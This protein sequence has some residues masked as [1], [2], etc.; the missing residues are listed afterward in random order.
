MDTNELMGVLESLLG[1][2]VAGLSAPAARAR[3][4]R[5]TSAPATEPQVA[6]ASEPALTP[7]PI[8]PAPPEP[9][10][11]PPTKVAHGSMTAL[12]AAE[13]PVGLA[14]L[15]ASTLTVNRANMP[16]INLIGKPWTETQIVGRT[17]QEIAPGFADSEVEAAFR[18]VA[19][20][21]TP[22]SAIIEES[23]PTGPIFRRCTLSAIRG[24]E[25]RFSEL[26]FTMLDVTEQM[27]ARQRAEIE[28]QRAEERAAR[29]EEQALRNSVRAAAMEALARVS[30]LEDA[31]GRVAERT[32]EALGDCCAVFLLGEDD[33]L[34]LSA[35]YH[36]DRG[37][38]FRMRAAYL[39][40]PLHRGEGLIGQVVLAGAGNLSARW[41]TGDLDPM[42]ATQRD[43]LRG[44]PIASLM[45]APLRESSRSFGAL[46][47]FSAREDSGGSARVYTGADLN[48]LQELADQ[49]AQAV[50]NVRLRDALRAAQGEREALLEASDEGIAIY[51]AQGRLRH[52][53]GI[54][55]QLLS[56]PTGAPSA[57]AADP[58][59]RRRFLSMSG[60]ELDGE[61]LPWAR[62]LQGERVGELAMERMVVEW[63]GGVRR[64]LA[65]RAVPVE[66]GSGG[67]CGAVL[68]LGD[69][70]PPTGDAPAG[71]AV[72]GGEPQPTAEAEWARWRETMELFADGVVLCDN[73]GTVV[74]VNTAGHELLNLP[75][76]PGNAQERQAP[77]G[78]WQRLRRPDGEPLAVGEDPAAM[79]LAGQ[80]VQDLETTVHLPS[81]GVRRVFWDARRIAGAVGD[82]LGVVLIARAATEATPGP[83][84]GP[85]TPLGAAPVSSPAT[86]LAPTTLLPNR[87]TPKLASTGPAPAQPATCDLAEVCARVA[88]AH[89][90]AQG[91]RLE[92]RLPRRQVRVLA[93]DGVVQAATDALITT[94]AATLPAAAPLHVAVWVERSASEPPRGPSTLVPPAV[95]VAQI[96]TLRLAPGQLPDLASIVPSTRAV[97]L[98]AG[99]ARTNVAVVRICSP[100]LGTGT[101]AGTEPPPE[102]VE[103][104]K[105]RSLV[106]QVGGRAWA[107]QD[108][109]LGPT[110]SFS[111]P[112]AE[113]A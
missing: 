106:A 50:Q 1:P 38:G 87:A 28:A 54:G 109:L 25:G 29:V 99:G 52:L 41:A 112:L 21:G 59:S 43:L 98:G 84:T 17:L 7:A 48:F 9:M 51:D 100:G 67:V 82:V 56:R 4:R 88:R 97:A 10:P 16:F 95:D 36:R 34:Q 74:F 31:L 32:A 80:T 89:S 110:Y 8:A 69:S 27:V 72:Q 22:F 39:A 3:A 2:A 12:L 105:C 78:L 81:G 92:I 14:V 45:C 103:F 111:I 60:M 91:R 33:V 30:D 61:Q 24:T 96:N 40:A 18:Q 20:T 102:T 108:P 85:L 90:G 93:E 58:A 71:P 46:L 104:L 94:G 44:A 65:V 76:P 79:A 77:T 19:R 47:L 86:A 42:G 63:G 70:A 101:T 15:S 57:D 37:L 13:T 68:L 64:E 62:A 55:R 5:A 83:T 66:D 53:N 75:T 107:K 35:L 23:T 49:I 11:L 26:L 6:P 73:S 113:N